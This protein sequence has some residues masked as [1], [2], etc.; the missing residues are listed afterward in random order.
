ME[1]TKWKK[2]ENEAGYP[3]YIDE[4]SG[5]QSY[6]HPQF[7][8]ILKTLDEYNDI[9]YSA[10][11][12]A[13][14]IFALQRSLKVPPLRISSGVF[15]RH[16][17]SLSESS[18]SL[19]TAELEAV[20]ADIYF[21][22]EK[23]GLFT[24][25][26]DLSVD[27][28][29]NLLLN[30]YDG[31]R[32]SPIRV[33][34]AKTLLI[35]LSEDSISEKWLALA[36]CCADHNGCVSRKRLAALLIHV[37]ALPKYLG[38]QCDY[39]ENDVDN[40]FEKSAGM[41]GISAHTVAEWGT[42]CASTR[43]LGVVQR[44]LDSRNCATASAVC[45]ICAQPL[46]QVLKFKCSKCNNIYF[47]EKC[48]LYGK[49]LTVVSG[50]KKTHSIHEI[51]DGEIKPPEHLGF[52]EGMSKFVEDM[53][54]LFLCMGTKK[55]KPS[56]RG[57]DRND[58][59]TSQ[60]TKTREV[61]PSMFTST[62]GKASGNK[63]NN[64]V[65]T[66]QDIIT[67][68]ENQ[69]KALMELSGQLQDGGKDTNNEL[70]ERVDAHYS[71]IS[72]QI[73]RLKSL[74]DNIANPDL[75]NELVV[76]KDVWPRAFEIFSPIPVAEKQSKVPKNLEQTKV[77]SMDSENLLATSKNHSQELLT[78]SGDFWKPIVGHTSDSVS[79]V[80]M[81]DISNWYYDSQ[82]SRV[83]SISRTEQRYL[84]DARSVQ[85]GTERVR[86]LSADIDS[87]LDRLQE[88]VTQTFTVDGSCFDNAQL[89][90]TAHELEGLLGTLIRG[91]EQ[92]A[93]LKANKT[94]V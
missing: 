34:A 12:I 66:L 4:A 52:I 11:R 69:N 42:H 55:K 76:E 50:H 27:L 68:L 16:Q 31:E 33:L 5:K 36:N 32:K 88:I 75:S 40:C 39:L 30:V 45:A 71:Q 9:K 37:T 35:L 41:L 61:T 74:K 79:T 1:L 70:K 73:N 78:M 58:V 23:E 60:S 53:E 18:L 93:T 19:D 28:L 83:D 67:Q 48:Y 64:P 10:Y 47:C 92:R 63:A 49:D 25:D 54:R 82:P 72:K 29:I 89:K 2:V 24:G 94:L 85:K 90:K 56:R 81:N 8:K 77:L 22:A 3:C 21:A 51:I 7:N 57:K 44:V 65:V 80:S 59:L 6:N 20:L 13:F 62:V 17:L 46:I 26:V 91:V 43:W 86:E 14:K 87:V 38:C 84:C 15:A